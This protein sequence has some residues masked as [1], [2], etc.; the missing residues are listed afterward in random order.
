VTIKFKCIRIELA[1]LSRHA[2]MQ[3]L[4]LSQQSPAFLEK[5]LKKL[6]KPKHI[7]QLESMTDKTLEFTINIKWP[8]YDSGSLDDDTMTNKS[9]MLSII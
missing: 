4:R 9:S 1:A 3:F 2:H 7:K 6:L 8:E 5:W